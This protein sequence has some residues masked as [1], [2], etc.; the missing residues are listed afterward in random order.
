MS[1]LLRLGGDLVG[2]AGENLDSGG[3]IGYCHRSF[4]DR[5]VHEPPTGP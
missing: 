2:G 1:A 5:S 4:I 3:V